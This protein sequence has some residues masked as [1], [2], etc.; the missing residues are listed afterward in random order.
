[1]ASMDRGD[2]EWT[3]LPDSFLYSPRQP[4]A[5]FKHNDPSKYIG[6]HMLLDKQRRR[7]YA[8][9]HDERGGLIS[10]V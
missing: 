6:D 1:M 8:Q 5:C 4:E 9:G 7:E 10:A 3:S 2:I